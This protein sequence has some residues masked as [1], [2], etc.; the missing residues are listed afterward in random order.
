MGTSPAAARRE[1]PT[2][3]CAHGCVRVSAWVPPV[4]VAPLALCFFL[5]LLDLLITKITGANS[6]CYEAP[7][8]VLILLGGSPLIASRAIRRLRR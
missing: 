7:A 6:Q 4:L 3:L 1:L 2:P 8:A 5:I